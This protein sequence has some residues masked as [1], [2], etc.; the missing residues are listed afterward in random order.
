MNQG[1]AAFTLTVCAGAYGL[2][3]CAWAGTAFG[4]GVAY[5]LYAQP[6][7]VSALVFVLLRAHCTT[8]DRLSAYAAATIAV[9]YLLWS[10]LGAL[11]LAA[12][13]FPA[14]LLLVVAVALTPSP[15]TAE[16]TVSCSA[17]RLV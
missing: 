15:Q 6:V 8:G 4:G 10:V 3:L 5:A 11:S 17:S 14:A 16:R 13:S 7:V 1:R 2:G 9:L 12:G